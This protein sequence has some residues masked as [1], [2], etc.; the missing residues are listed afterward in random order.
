MIDLSDELHRESCYIK[1][2]TECL[3]YGVVGNAKRALA[4]QSEWTEVSTRNLIIV[5]LIRGVSVLVP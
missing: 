2:M 5:L 3:S 1:S 4:A